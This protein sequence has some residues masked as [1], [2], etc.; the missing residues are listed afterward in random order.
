MRKAAS[1]CRSNS[2]ECSAQAAGM[3]ISM[4][5]SRATSRCDTD[6][7][8]R[9]GLDP[10][11]ARRQA[12]IRLGGVEQIRQTYRE[13]RTL[14][15]LENLRLDVRY[16]IR[17]LHNSPG[18]T[19]TAVLTLG[20]GIGANTAIFT[21]VHAILL[22]QLPFNNP[23]HVLMVDNGID[24][25]LGFD[26]RAKSESASFNEAAASFKTIE[27]A[28]MYSSTGVNAALGE[29]I[30]Q[31]LR[32]AETGAYF[33]DVLGADSAL[34]AWFRIR[35]RF[36]GQ[37]SCGFSQRSSLAWWIPRRSSGH[38]KEDQDQRIRFR[39]HRGSA[40]ANGFSRQRRS[41][42]THYFRQ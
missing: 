5:N 27:S 28:T 14:P 41:L 17:Q 24:V 13:R 23:S 6:A 9:E 37:R 3:R 19:I 1:T 21:L 32:A 39:D 16:A 22:R 25:G 35:R 20:L 7:G 40:I 31:R 34:G 42:D 38:W 8:I 12:L 30:S 29:G 33:L 36:T 4:P 10:V 18:F 2:L 26:M 11:E 15:W